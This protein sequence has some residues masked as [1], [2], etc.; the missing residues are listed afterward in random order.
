MTPPEITSVMDTPDP[1]EVGGY[2]NITCDVDDNVGV[3]EVW[4]NITYP[5]TTTHNFS[6]NIGSYHHNFSMNIGSYHYN[7]SYS[8]VGN[9]TYFIWANDTNG[10]SN[11]STGH[12]FDIQVMTPPEITNVTDYPDPQY[13]GGSIISR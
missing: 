7:Q 4:V 8:T 10:N 2:V 13:A 5:D 12:S 3:D 6:M 9:Y 11:M 1:Q